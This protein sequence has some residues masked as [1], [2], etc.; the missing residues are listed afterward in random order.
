LLKETESCVK[1]Y[2]S[3]KSIKEMSRRLINILEE[4]LEAVQGF[5]L[6]TQYVENL[7]KEK[8]P[9]DMKP[10]KKA[11][12][13]LRK[14]VL[15]NTFLNKNFKVPLKNAREEFIGTPKSASTT[16]SNSRK[17][18]SKHT[19]LID[20]Q[21]ILNK[22]DILEIKV[23]QRG[24]NRC[25]S[26][27]SKNKKALNKTEDE[28]E[29]EAIFHNLHQYKRNNMSFEMVRETYPDSRLNQSFVFDYL[30]STCYPKKR[31]HIRSNSDV[32]QA[33]IKINLDI[34]FQKPVKINDF[35]V[36]K[37]ISSGAYGKVC[38]AKKRS[39]GDYFA[40]KLIDRE[41]TIEKE[42]EDYIISELS[43]M[44]HVNSDY[45]VK[46]YYSFQNE[47]YWFFVMEYINGGDLASLLQN[48]GYLEEPYARLYIAEIIV[49][50]EYLHSMNILHR[51]L[52]PRNILIDSTGHLKIT[53]FGLSKTKIK[54]RKWLENYWH[55]KGLGKVVL[56]HNKIVGT[57]HYIAPETIAENKCTVES[58]WWALGIIAFEI[59]TG[60][61]P[62][63]GNTPEEVFENI[64]KENKSEEIDIGYDEG[65]VS[66]LAADLVKKLLERDPNKRIKGEE[67]KQH[68]FFEGLDWREL[69]QQEPPFVPKPVNIT[70]TSYFNE[71]KDTNEGN[72]LINNNVLLITIY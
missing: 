53:D 26:P 39:T 23:P 33:K 13:D 46:L 65:Q 10:L 25:L 45:I 52:K 20:L 7:K 19:L 22:S 47:N 21:D 64:L 1:V 70:D 50:L 32:T 56:T 15:K 40:I 51:D 24:K 71:K 57:P 34:S 43:I 30:L 6:L 12:K 69:R 31:R 55:E 67:L 17:T 28:E 44:R 27:T 4:K 72:T 62:Y 5:D 14:L 68:P 48:C 61:P 29:I 42:Q 59:L 54:S 36:I 41:K 35:E 58:D 11:C 38:L 66:P 18:S 60:I 3:V 16:E 49:A 8:H 63:N 37:R 9:L 2:I